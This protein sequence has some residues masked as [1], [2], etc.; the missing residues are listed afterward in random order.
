MSV[1]PGWFGLQ[2]KTLYQKKNVKENRTLCLLIAVNIT[3]L[4]LFLLKFN[5]TS[6][7]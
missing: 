4:G 2:S 7:Y 5:S 1:K 3:S 6:I